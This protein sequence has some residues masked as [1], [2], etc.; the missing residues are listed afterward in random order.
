MGVVSRGRQVLARIDESGVVGGQRAV[1]GGA[2]RG[3][4]GSGGPNQR[5]WPIRRRRVFNDLWD[6]LLCGG[7]IGGVLGLAIGEA[8]VGFDGGAGVVGDRR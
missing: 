1:R 8:D 3:R 4:T 5:P 6:C 7:S 2:G